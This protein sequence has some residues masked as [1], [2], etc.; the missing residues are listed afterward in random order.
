MSLNGCLFFSALPGLPAF[1]QD[2]RK[3]SPCP[4]RAFRELKGQ[5][6]RNPTDKESAGFPV[7]RKNVLQYFVHRR[8]VEAESFGYRLV[9]HLAFYDVQAFF[10]V[11]VFGAGLFPTFVSQLEGVR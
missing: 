5:I 2:K 4:D 11:F 1:W 7:V 8:V 3:L 6:K 10:Q 9:H